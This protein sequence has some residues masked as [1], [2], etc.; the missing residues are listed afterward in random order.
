MLKGYYQVRMT[1][2]GGG[3][4][5]PLQAKVQAVT[6]FRQPTTKQDICAFLG[7]TCYYQ[8]FI[9]DYAMRTTNLTCALGSKNPEK[10]EWKAEMQ[11]EFKDLKAFLSGN[12]VLHTPDFD[13]GLLS[14]LMYPLEHIGPVPSQ[15][16]EEDGEERPVA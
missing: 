2:G 9:P 13:R 7:L 16:V 12:T 14:R 10:V 11:Q 1:S 15:H 4:V 3:V 8:H 6:E 5:G